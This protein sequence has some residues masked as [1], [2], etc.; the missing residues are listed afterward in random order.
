MTPPAVIEGCH[1]AVPGSQYVVIADS[2][3]STYFEQPVA[4]NTAVM[5]FLRAYSQT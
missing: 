5:A 4:F 1:R 3:H 2:G